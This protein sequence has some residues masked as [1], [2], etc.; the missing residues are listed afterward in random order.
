ML[1]PVAAF[2]AVAAKADAGDKPE[3]RI[4]QPEKV[5][6]QAVFRCPAVRRADATGLERLL[7][8][9]MTDTDAVFAV[10]TKAELQTGVWVDLKVEIALVRAEGEEKLH[11]AVL[12]D[13]AERRGIFCANGGFPGLLAD[14]ER[15][16]IVTELLPHADAAVRFPENRI[17]K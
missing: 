13:G 7:L 12:M 4:E 14:V 2:I 11:T 9:L 1:R 10:Q 6:W 15:R 5:Q 3:V 16:F 17:H 8:C